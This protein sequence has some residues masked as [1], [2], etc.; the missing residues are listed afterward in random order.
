[1]RATKVD[2]Q[3]T[4]LG[5]RAN[6]FSSLPAETARQQFT[7]KPSEDH[8]LSAAFRQGEPTATTESICDETHHKVAKSAVTDASQGRMGSILRTPQG[9]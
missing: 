2:Y 8:R 9:I 5:L 7:V 4:K 1:M 6:T 3:L